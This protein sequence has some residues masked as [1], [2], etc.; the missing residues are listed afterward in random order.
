MNPSVD[1]GPLPA[2]GSIETFSNI[3]GVGVIR[4][5]DGRTF[6]F[7]Q[8][9]CKGF[10]AVVGLRVRVIEA[11]RHFAGGFRATRV[12]LPE[13]EE[14][15]Y[16]TLLQERDAAAGHKPPTLEMQV[17]TAKRMG[18]I[19]VL[20]DDPQA[21][22][23]LAGVR[24]RGERSLTLKFGSLDVHA[25]V[26]L[27]P[28]PKEEFDRR[29]LPEGFDVGRAFITL[30]FGL[31]GVGR[32]MRE[33]QIDRGDPWGED[34]I[35]RNVSRAAEVLL[36]A[37]RG[38]IVHRAQ[39]RAYTREQF[40]GLL[41]DPNDLTKKPFR[42]WVVLG[43]DAERT[44]VLTSGMGVFGLPDV[45]A[46]I[47][48]PR[49][50]WH[51]DRAI[52]AALVFAHAMIAQNRLLRAGEVVEVPE[53]V[54][55]GQGPL[56]V[57]PDAE[58]HPWR[59]V[60]DRTDLILERTPGSLEPAARWALGDRALSLASYVGLYSPRL[61]EEAGATS[62]ATWTPRSPRVTHD[63]EVFTLG[64]A[65]YLVSTVGLARVEPRVELL[66]RTMGHGPRICAI[67]SAIADSLGPFSHGDKLSFD[68][69]LG[70]TR[71]VLAARGSLSLGRG[72]AVQLAEIIPVEPEEYPSLD[73]E[74]AVALIDA[75][76][77]DQP[78]AAAHARIWSRALR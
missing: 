62:V 26:A 41:G 64:Q 11:A 33:A 72:P 66:T 37:G 38:V 44:R 13:S 25:E 71:F 57:P 45:H 27:A 2:E 21:A 75:L 55:V 52:E 76:D 60:D 70:V 48:D 30:S 59:V 31:P 1:P 50:Q 32:A 17:A 43:V 49:S 5:A 78:I 15:E 16:R 22:L 4:T 46:P 56:V 12:E 69:D 54:A 23:A 9:G 6:R 51:F 73:R 19:S 34:G 18:W 28:F 65:G 36:R 40:L 39:D 20:L 68:N 63:I 77:H 24:W 42:P 14:G 3:D 74:R 47:G 61:A 67:V 10:S 29:P 7:G 8:S 53:D 35:A 58:L